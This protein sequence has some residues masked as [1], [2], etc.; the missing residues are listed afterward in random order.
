[1]LD[2]EII[3]YDI[4]VEPEIYLDP[5]QRSHY[6]DLGNR[7]GFNPTYEGFQSR[8]QI[9]ISPTGTGKSV[10]GSF[11]FAL[12]GLK[13]LVIIAP[14]TVG[15][16]WI[17]PTEWL[18]IENVHISTY[19][20]IIATRGA[21]YTKAGFTTKSGDGKTYRITEDFQ[22]M[23]DEGVLVIFD[24]AEEIK[25][26][27]AGKTESAIAMI[28]SILSYK[29]TKSRVILMSATAT[30]K[31]EM[32]YVWLRH[33]GILTEPKLH[34]TSRK[35]KGLKGGGFTTI[36][37]T[38]G[39]NSIRNWILD[40]EYYIKEGLKPYYQD[41]KYSTETKASEEAENKYYRMLAKLDKAIKN[42]ATNEEYEQK[43]IDSIFNNVVIPLFTSSMPNIK[44]KRNWAFTLIAKEFFSK[45]EQ[46]EIENEIEDI[47]LHVK[48]NKGDRNYLSRIISFLIFMEKKKAKMF[49]PL[50][51]SLLKEDKNR[52]IIV[53]LN[54]HEA[55]EI[56]E[57]GLAKKYG[58]TYIYG[59]YL[60]ARGGRSPMSI[61]ERK[62]QQSKFQEFNNNYRI[63]V[64]TQVGTM[65]IDLD[66]KS[67]GGKHP[68]ILVTPS[69]YLTSKLAQGMGRPWR[70]DT[71]S[72]SICILV[73]YNLDEK[74][75][76][77][78][79]QKSKTLRKTTIGGSIP[80]T[81]NTPYAYYDKSSGYCHYF[82]VIKKGVRE[83]EYDYKIQFKLGEFNE[84]AYKIY[85]EINPID[86]TGLYT[87]K[88]PS[89]IK[90]ICLT[91]KNK[92]KNLLIATDLEIDTEHFFASEPEDIIDQINYFYNKI[93]GDNTKIKEI[94]TIEELDYT[95]EV[96]Y[97]YPG[98]RI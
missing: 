18:N 5:S 4:G 53:Q 16:I 73:L 39:L 84:K 82:S 11:L 32:R 19:R 8:V 38:E 29:E 83:L 3:E 77:R 80:I 68:R 20:K 90:I 59:S 33:L 52:K 70:K 28:S 21:K 63:M 25:N 24:E 86:M 34:T 10:V 55:T 27:T 31:D 15:P 81:D 26:S 87:P 7:L 50:I 45:E 91:D 22:K 35:R 60:N 49:V 58:L 2:N 71:T 66:D 96:D 76:D 92:R 42:P 23:I 93:L 75:I 14:E 1:M 62:E 41:A 95:K 98:F 88:S 65:G 36:Y 78:H 89:V 51:D 30:D 47:T 44:N 61:E 17:K 57:R 85:R 12:S 43:A 48:T 69:S 64:L 13:H 67:P 74:L 79:N 56:I 97:F 72:D 46:E 6:I 54:Y 94:N 40:N 9:D 37:H